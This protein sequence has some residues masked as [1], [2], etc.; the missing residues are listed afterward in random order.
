M[1]TTTTQLSVERRTK[2][3]QGKKKK[4]KNHKN[5]SLFPLS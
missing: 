3:Q 2:N 4:A 5:L 1:P